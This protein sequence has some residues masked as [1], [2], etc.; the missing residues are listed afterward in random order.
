MEEK[1]KSDV[2]IIENSQAFS[3]WIE[4]EL[5]KNESLRVVGNVGTRSL[6]KELIYQLNPRIIILDMKLDDGSGIDLLKD[7]KVNNHPTKVVVFT[8][9]NFYK[10]ECLRLG[11]DYFFDKS[12]EFEEMIKSVNQLVENQNNF[13]KEIS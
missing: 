2:L 6:G 13:R 1:I 12:N 3:I 10:D 4:S 7:I 8:N 9:Y 5:K 11:C